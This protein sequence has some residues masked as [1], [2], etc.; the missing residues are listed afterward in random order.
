MKERF[1]FLNG[2]KYIY[3]FSADKLN[4]LVLIFSNICLVIQ[5][6]SLVQL[7]HKTR[8]KH[9]YINYIKKMAIN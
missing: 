1:F 9:N 4:C 8:E 3:C 6:I 5:F 2:K 7:T